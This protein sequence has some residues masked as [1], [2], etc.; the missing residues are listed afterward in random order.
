MRYTCRCKKILTA[1]LSLTAAGL[2]IAQQ[3]Q[4]K[5]KI[6]NGNENLASASVSL[7]ST[8]K[9]T[10]ANGVFEFSLPAGKYNLIISY[11]GYSKIEGT[12]TVEA[13]KTKNLNY[14]LAPLEQIGDEVVI[15]SLSGIRRSNLNTP[16]PVQ[17]ISSTNLLQTGQP[18]FVQMLGSTI[19]S[20]NISRQ[21]AWDPVTF[22]GLNP[23]HVILLVDGVRYHPRSSIVALQGSTGQL[24]KGAVV[25]DFYGISYSAIEK[26]EILYDGA[27]AQFGSD[28]IAA[29]VNIHLKKS[30]GNTSIQLH[31]GQY[32]KN[33]GETI[34]IGINH[35][36]KIFR[37]GFINLSADF[38]SRART[39]RG[40]IYPGTVYYDLS[41]YDSSLHEYYVALD[42]Q[43][44]IDSGFDRSRVPPGYESQKLNSIG[45]LVVGG[46]PLSENWELFWTGLANYR[47]PSYP[48]SFRLPKNVQ[49]L[50]TEMYPDGFLPETN[51]PVW[52]LSLKVG[53][54]GTTKN[55]WSWNATGVYGKN[56]ITIETHNNNN[57]S[58]QFLMGKNAQTDFKCGGSSFSQFINNINFTKQIPTLNTK[59]QSITIA[60]GSE[61]RLEN[62]QVEPG[63]EA[64]WKNYDATG[65]R[66]GGVQGVFVSLDS[67]KQSESRNVIAL[68][69]DI[70]TEINDRLLIDNAV[71]FEHY[72]DFGANL[73]GKLAARYK[74]SDRFLLRGSISNNFRAPPLQQIYYSAAVNAKDT[75]IDSTGQ[76]H[77]GTIGIFR[78]DHDVIRNGFG[79]PKLKP[80]KAI[81]I[82]AGITSNIS[83]FLS[84][85]V[86]AYWI[87]VKDR[88]VFSGRFD[89]LKNPAVKEILKQFPGI[90]AVH[91]AC[92]A[93]NTRTIGG[94]IVVNSRWNFLKGQLGFT[95]AVNLNRTHIYGIVQSAAN[96][97]SDSVNTNT[98]FNR[99]EIGRLEKSQ[100]SSKIIL[101]TFYKKGNWLVTMINKRFGSTE[102]IHD[103][104]STQD[105]FF[106]GKI[107]T[108]LNIK[109]SPKTWYSIT[110]G[111][112]N[113]FNVA[114]DRVEN[115][116]N[117]NDGRQPYGSQYIPFSPNGGYYFVSMGFNFLSKNKKASQ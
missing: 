28:A 5:G 84:L 82:S 74:F 31:T 99:G 8:T 102:F 23:D 40:N 29:V 115:Y 50:N 92:N 91:F 106:S 55:N 117:S 73:A 36:A 76:R 37:K 79:V 25:N 71:R 13:G 17:V 19:P 1:A 44:I 6:T 56:K 34:N 95:F 7:G 104:T 116:L 41:K 26:I 75:W 68:Y 109:F 87:Q 15:H 57:A 86:D 10:D 103:T 16:V 65:R 66:Q 83:S 111:A 67:N 14:E 35:G 12:V 60:L 46:M 89:T 107:I 98:L 47:N 108:D 114:P 59:L 51:A 85:T 38:H 61:F 53:A 45:F 30:P 20:F 3:G 110:I 100:P 94:D 80:E 64:S 97:P 32:Y 63:E 33:D 113:I 9:L 4:V 54:R 81:N 69:A 72:S 52:D 27:S 112:N 2:I 90:S 24:G 77:P 39:F 78:N 93:V 21:Q 49:Q 96:L 18:S 101:T 11:I 43:K 105:E 42:N 22:R 62:Y 58:Q 70:E 88:I 48:M